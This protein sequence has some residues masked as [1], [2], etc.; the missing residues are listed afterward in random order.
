MGV[1]CL[2][3]CY[4]D[5]AILQAMDFTLYSLHSISR[6][7]ATEAYRAGAEQMQI[8]R[9]GLWSSD[10]FGDYVTPTCAQRSHVASALAVCPE[11]FMA[12]PQG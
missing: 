2:H 9:H 5:V 8:K 6:G 1:P 11:A 3:G 4:I 12:H 10:S 7:G